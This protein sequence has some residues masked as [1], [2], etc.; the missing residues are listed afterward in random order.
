MDVT[1]GE[2][3]LVRV[4]G[5]FGGALA[6]GIDARISLQSNHYDPLFRKYLRTAND[7]ENGNDWA[8]RGQL[9]FK[10]PENSQL[11][12][13]GRLTAPTCTRAPGRAH[14][15]NIAPGIDVY[16]APNDNPYGTCPGCNASGLANSG[17]FVIRDSISGF[18]G[19]KAADSPRSTPGTQ[20]AAALTVVATTLRCARTTR[21]TRTPRWTPSPVLQRQQGEPTVAEAR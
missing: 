1:F 18:T 16:A 5:A 12:L 10:L 9:L 11:L 3:N 7:A 15:M 4:E 8:L 14:P 19:S 2:R 20:D 17:P 21:R 13:L 6:E